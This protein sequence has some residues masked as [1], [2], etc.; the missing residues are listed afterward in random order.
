MPP[1][2][3]P[4]WSVEFLRFAAVGTVGAVAHYSL[5]ILAVE[6]MGIGAV[7]ASSAGAVLGALV[8][9]ALNR[10]FTFNSDKSHAEALAKFLTIAGVGF[11]L[12]GLLMALFVEWLGIFYL[13]SQ[14]LATGLV[15][16]WNFLGNRFWTFRDHQPIP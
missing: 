6:G 13:L 14:L 12:N 5:L 10:R 8:N 1:V 11:V 15:L 4:F 3:N 16:M 7:A 2:R 9:Y